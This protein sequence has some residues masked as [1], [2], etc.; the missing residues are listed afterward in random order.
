MPGHM[1]R[2]RYDSLMSTEAMILLT[3]LV[4]GMG[5]AG[6]IAAGRERRH[7]KRV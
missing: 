7:A 3:V 4:L 1:P 5:V 2:M 6:L